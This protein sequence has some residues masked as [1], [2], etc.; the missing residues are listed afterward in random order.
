MMKT[1]RHRSFVLAL[2][3]A[4]LI[5]GAAAVAASSSVQSR[6]WRL[7]TANH[8]RD[9][10]TLVSGAKLD[11][12]TLKIKNKGD[13]AALTLSTDRDRAPFTVTSTTKV[14]R[15]NAD[16]LDGLDSSAFQRVQ[17]APLSVLVLNPEPQSIP[18]SSLTSLGT[19]VEMYDPSDMHWNANPSS[20]MAPQPGTYVVSATVAWAPGGAGW[21]NVELRSSSTVVV[22]V[23]GPAAGPSVPT[24][25]TLTGIV[26]LPVQSGV[27]LQVS[28]SSG[29]SP[30]GATMTAFE[31]AYVGP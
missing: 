31:M 30:L 14:D 2:G 19:Y 23:A 4:A 12:A 24:V 29:G 20:L 18:D 8:A 15:L 5:V 28:Q 7:G 21:R 26:H 9:T 10:T 6:P 17:A 13:G 1:Q 25:Q 27:T 3:L 22:R 16:S 11:D